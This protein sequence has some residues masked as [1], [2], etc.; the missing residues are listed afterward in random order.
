MSKPQLQFE[1]LYPY[2]HRMIQHIRENPSCA[3][4]VDMGLGKS[5]STLTAIKGMLEDFDAAHV[6]VVAPLRVARKT[7]TDE[8]ETWAHLRG[9][10]TS[11]I[12][13]TAQQRLAG[14][15][16]SA[17]IH[18]INRENLE[19]LAGYFMEERN[20]KW[21]K[22]AEWPWDTVIID[23]ATSFKNQ[24][25][26]R[27]RAMRRLRK[28]IDRM[29]QL[30]GLPAPNGLQDVWAQAYLLDR[31]ARLGNTFKAFRDRWMQPPDHLGGRWTLKP[32]A[33]AQ[34]H[35][36]IGDLA[37]AMRAEDYL[38]LPPVMSNYIRVEMTPAE[39]KQY[40]NFQRTY[41]MDIAG[42][43]LTAANA[44]VLWGKLLQLANGA[45]YT[46]HPAW[47]PF[48]Q[49]KVDALMELHDVVPGAMLVVYNYQSDLARIERAFQ[50]DKVNYRV[51]KTEQD[52][53]D[54][55]EGRVDRLVLHPASAGHGLNI[56]KCGAEEIVWFGLNANFE[57]YDQCNA[58][59]AGGHR[60]IGKNVR[61]HHIVTD[62]TI[63][64][65]VVSALRDKAN[66]NERLMEATKRM[67]KDAA[68]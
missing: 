30:T 31:G 53:V 6:L 56:H 47:E 37:L 50:K 38:D 11:K 36:A 34:I 46:Q 66:V 16:R 4:W 21:Y 58:R 63:D 19:W 17:D 28:W 14:A 1:D 15:L 61:I 5:V 55:N 7:W 40:R 42:Q 64:D 23:E 59:L 22:I 45:I 68:A 2:Q 44:G 25:T 43:R 8:I 48:H 57:Y 51:L 10:T 35:A 41:V 26:N 60:R 20:K 27:Y 49:R 67:M 62:H 9:L 12:I 13:G 29:I 3:L 32:G 18:L 39:M 33:E 65:D 54:W 24:D 52:E